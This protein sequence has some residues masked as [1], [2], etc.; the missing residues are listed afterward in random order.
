MH[1][2]VNSDIF[3][4]VRDPLAINK[5]KE[6]YSLPDRYILFVS[7]LIPIK[8]IENLISAYNLLIKNK[9][10]QDIHLVIAGSKGW[11][12]KPIFE[13]VE[14]LG[15]DKRVIFTGFFPQIDLPSLYSAAELFVL[16][17]IYEGFGIPVVE[18]FACGTPVITS[19][20]SCL[21]EIAGDAGLTADPHNIHDLADKM[22]AALTDE[23]L[24]QEMIAK[25][26]N[27]ARHFSW[28]RAAQKTLQTYEKASME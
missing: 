6:K 11:G 28:E 3:Y 2:G 12:T 14:K 19:N 9:A 26:L 17:S 15:I 4:P 5:L 10:F 21:P 23:S 20:T 22:E 8:N 7:A 16:P 25:G 27:R 1:H 18:A 13:T 24:R